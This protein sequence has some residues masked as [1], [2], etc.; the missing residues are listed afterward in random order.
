M[1]ECELRILIAKVADQ[2]VLKQFAGYRVEIEPGDLIQ[3]RERFVRSHRF[4]SVGEAYRGTHVFQST[5]L[6]SCGD[7]EPDSFPIQGRVFL[8][9]QCGPRWSGSHQIS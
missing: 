8:R 7:V 2:T 4:D 9:L 1:L 3:R 6:L 5:E